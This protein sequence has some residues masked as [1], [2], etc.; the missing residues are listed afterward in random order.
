[1]DVLLESEPEFPRAKNATEFVFGNWL[2]VVPAIRELRRLNTSLGVL[3]WKNTKL[4]RVYIQHLVNIV[5]GK[6]S[7]PA[8]EIDAAL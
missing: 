6:E 4:G 8:A 5:I 2:D 7:P 1:M 3:V